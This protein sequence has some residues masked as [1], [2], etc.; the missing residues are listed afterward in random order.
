MATVHESPSRPKS[1]NHPPPSNPQREPSKED[2]EL[3]EQLVNHAKGIQSN[4]RDTPNSVHPSPPRSSASPT[5]SG[6][7]HLHSYAPATDSQVAMDSTNSQTRRSGPSAITSGQ[8]CSNCGTTRT[9][10]WRRSPTGD[11]ICNA[12]GLYL[13]ARNQMRPVGMR[14]QLQQPQYDAMS[15]AAGQDGPNSDGPRQAGS[16]A[17]YGPA[18]NTVAGTCPGG[19]RCNGTGGHDGCNGCP[20]YNNRVAK[21]AQFALA[22]TGEGTPGPPSDTDGTSTRTESP[23]PHAQNMESQNSVNV[24]VA[25]QNCGTTVTPLWRRD[26]EGHTICNA[27]GLYHK[28]HGVHRPV[29]MKKSE[30]KRRKRVVPAMQDQNHAYQSS[31]IPQHTHSFQDSSHSQH[32]PTSN[33]TPSANRLAFDN[34]MNPAPDHPPYPSH[35]HAHASSYDHQRDEESAHGTSLHSADSDHAVPRGPVPVDFTHYH[36]ARRNENT[37]PPIQYDE[38]RRKRSFSQSNSDTEAVRIAPQQERQ[39]GM[40]D[41]SLASILNVDTT[42]S[43]MLSSRPK[44]AN[45]LKREELQREAAHFRE[46]LAAKERELAALND[47]T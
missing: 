32:T 12:C 30:I 35:N 34:L 11:T 39:P 21:T 9:P 38:N 36:P 33:P 13:K 7:V 6:E 37:L 47:G 42:S 4:V 17:A 22:Q 5:T 23:Y 14:R 29:Q 44:D 26:E 25:C 28:L 27:C 8:I 1:A 45:Q 41:P 46:M 31:G 2:I 10:L 3:A 20:A 18:D 16:N 40:I 43:T 15:T 19:G 24:V